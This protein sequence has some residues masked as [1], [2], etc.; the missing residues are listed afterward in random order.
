V[1]LDSPLFRPLP[2]WSVEQ[3]GSLVQYIERLEIRIPT[4]SIFSSYPRELHINFKKD[5]YETWMDGAL[6]TI[7]DVKV[8]MWLGSRSFLEFSEIGKQ[9]RGLLDT[10]EAVSRPHKWIVRAVCE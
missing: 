9:T 7:Q 1:I 5:V 3:L 8:M 2:L 6:R 4:P 10:V